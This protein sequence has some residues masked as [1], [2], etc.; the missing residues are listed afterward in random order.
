VRRI[1]SAA[2]RRRALRALCC[3]VLAWA[4]TAGAAQR[5][6]PFTSGTAATP[7]DETERRAWGHSKDLVEQIVRGGVI[8]EDSALTVYVQGIVDRLFPEFGGRMRVTVLKSPHLNAFAIPDGH[9][10]VN[11]GLIAR[12][13]NEAQLATVMAHEGVHFTH[14]HGYLSAR[15]VKDNAAMATI[16]SLL[17]IPI[18]PQ[19]LAASSMFGYSRELETEADESGYQRLVQAGYDVREAPRTFEHLLRDVKIE[20]IEEP[21]FFST[22]PKLQDRLDNM[23]RLSAKAVG[24][25]DGDSREAYSAIVR[26]A[27]LDTLE[28]L[29][30]MGRAK[31]VV[32]ML[33]DAQT[34]AE[35]PPQARFF[36][37]EG[38]RLRG[39]PG[40]AQRAESVYRQ[41]AE[42][43]PDYAPPYR[44][45]GIMLLKAGRKPDAARQFEHYL[46]LAPEARDRKY[47]ESYLRSA[48]SEENSK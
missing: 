21:F 30:S 32:A 27:R 45:L 31:Q 5:V 47:V 22:H 36:L 34:Q 9:L 46:S 43:A 38:Y 17:G 41:V 12:F 23:K 29:L 26:Q 7:A 35:L 15:N 28:N 44:A 3:A 4:A 14:R 6:P 10:Y 1:V 19:L 37:G 18:L 11:V 39:E 16:G 2:A 42:A 20:K 13:H 40:D 8:Y 24:G 48:R 25:G 33:E